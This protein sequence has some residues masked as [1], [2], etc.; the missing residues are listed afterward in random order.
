MDPFLQ[1]LF[2]AIVLAVRGLTT[3]GE[4]EG[5]PALTNSHN[6]KLPKWRYFH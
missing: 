3:F 1:L 6:Q 4:K 5:L 2:I